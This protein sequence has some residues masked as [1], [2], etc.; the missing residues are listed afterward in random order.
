MYRRGEEEAM[1]T[2]RAQE[3]YEGILQTLSALKRELELTGE[4]SKHEADAIDEIVDAL[5]HLE[6]Q[7]SHVGG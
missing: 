4:A 5:K 6:L 1:E 3:V 2:A 7:T